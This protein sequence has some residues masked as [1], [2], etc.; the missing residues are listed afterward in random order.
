MNRATGRK[1]LS[2][3][4]EAPATRLLTALGLSPNAITTIGLLGA[5]ASAVLLGLGYLGAGGAALLLSGML[6]VLDGAVARATGKASPSGALLDSVVDRVSEAVVLLGLL[7]FYLDDQSAFNSVFTSELGLL[8]VYVALAGSVMVS[9][10]RARAE[11]LGVD[12]S[13]GIMTRPE[14]V[15]VLGV[16][17]VLSEWWLPAATVA[18]GLI[19]VLALTT[20]LQ[21]VLHVR[22]ALAQRD[23]GPR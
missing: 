21:R 8:L 13:V 6:D 20:S 16:G 2:S 4:F 1:L 11:G 23:R 9:Y 3:Y 12:A 17:L 19:A 5:V 22:K 10:V 15:A 7:V 14:R 18:L